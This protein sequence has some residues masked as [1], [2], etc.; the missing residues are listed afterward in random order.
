MAKTE[1][2]GKQEKVKIDDYVDIS[3]DTKELNVQQL[4]KKGFTKQHAEDLVR[5][6]YI[7]KRFASDSR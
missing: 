4:I 7:S 2:I 6:H 3:Y 1:D 5:K